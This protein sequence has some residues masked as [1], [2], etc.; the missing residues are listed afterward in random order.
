MV[1]VVVDTS[2]VLKWLNQIDE[3]YIAEAE[4]L[5][6]AA[7]LN[8]IQLLAPELLKY[9]IGNVLLVAKKLSGLEIEEALDFFYAIPINFIP[10][11]VSLAASSYEIGRNLNITYYDA[12]FI[13]LAKEYNATLVTDNIKHQG[14]DSGINVV[15]LKDY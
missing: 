7:K 6:E 12:S 1:R 14:R 5:L 9:E 15:A 2:V 10:E 8:K 3:K 11:T 13:S 4:K